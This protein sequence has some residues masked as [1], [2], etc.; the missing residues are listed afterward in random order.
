MKKKKI[1]RNLYDYLDDRV[2]I[3]QY[4]MDM[5]QEEIEAEIKKIEANRPPRKKDKSGPYKI[6]DTTILCL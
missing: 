1:K 2:I 6:G 5:S 4:I 3:P